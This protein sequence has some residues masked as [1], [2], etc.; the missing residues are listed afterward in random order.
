MAP[1]VFFRY[2]R[3]QEIYMNILY[4]DIQTVAPWPDSDW[5]I[6]MLVSARNSWPNVKITD[7]SIVNFN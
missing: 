7:I 5:P 6:P 4:I 1:N 2:F 3:V